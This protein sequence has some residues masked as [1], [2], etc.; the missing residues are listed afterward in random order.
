MRMT[1]RGMKCFWVLAAGC[2]L[3]SGCGGISKVLAGHK[4]SAPA[5]QAAQAA[6]ETTADRTE[7]RK[8]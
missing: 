6:A 5:N 7:I 3:I 4:Y 8:A 2:L 1:K